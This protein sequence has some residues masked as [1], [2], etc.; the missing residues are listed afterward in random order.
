MRRIDVNVNR[1]R[2]FEETIQ[3]LGGQGETLFPTLREALSFAALLG[4]KERRRLP[5]DKN[6]G[7]EDIS[8][9]QYQLNEAVDIILA[10]ALAE[11]KSTEIFK[12]SNEKECVVI[13]EE[14]ANGGLQLIQEWLETY[15]NL[16]AED[17]L[18]KGL[19]SIGFSMPLT[20]THS[21]EIVEP[22]F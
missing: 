5:L 4:Y 19:K 16:S 11:A 12:P 8:S 20:S 9:G 21:G 7:V 22:D 1:S 18:W 17:A 10:L 13:F 14:Y 6:A 15:A 3:K 2:L